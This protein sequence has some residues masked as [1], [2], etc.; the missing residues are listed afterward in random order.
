VQPA[1]AGSYS[2]VVSNSAGSVTSAPAQLTIV[3]A[4][5]ITLQ[6]QGVTNFQGQTV[7]FSVAAVGNAPLSYQWMANCSRP[8]SGATSSTLRL[9]SVGSLDSGSYCVVV[10]NVLGSVLSQPA[11]LRVLVQSKLVTLSDAKGSATFS[12]TTV[13]NL[14]YSVYFTDT[15]SA[16]N[17]TLLP[18]MFQQPGT[19]APMT[20]HDATASGTQRF[21]RL[22]VQ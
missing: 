14:L 12:I 20:V 11:V 22:L 3:G 7:V 17:W 13:T 2:V 19:G 4:P 5:T 6:P 21:Y 18:N 9:K 16:T 1:E 10:S 15:L 8:I